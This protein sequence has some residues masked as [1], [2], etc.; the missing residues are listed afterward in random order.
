MCAM[1][2][3]AAITKLMLQIPNVSDVSRVLLPGQWCVL[4]LDWQYSLPGLHVS[5][6][7]SVYRKYNTTTWTPTVLCYYV[8][9]HSLNKQGSFFTLICNV[10]V[11]YCTCSGSCII[12]NHPASHPPTQV[13]QLAQFDIPELATLLDASLNT[14]TSH[15]ISTPSTLEVIL[16]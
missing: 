10:V 12:Y 13:T 4:C 11:V 2:P 1:H 8:T 3:Y 6:I 5:Y 16:Q 15:F 14:S 9:N 7:Y